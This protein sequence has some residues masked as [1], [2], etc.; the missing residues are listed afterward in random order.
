MKTHSRF[1]SFLARDIEQFLAHKRVLGRRYDV[2]EKTLVLL[3][4]Y[5]KLHRIGSLK[6][7]T[8]RLVDEF[9]LSRPRARPRSYN[10]L[11]CTLVRLFAYMV[12]RGRLALTPVQSPPR[13]SRYQRTPFIFDAANAERLLA[14][15]R[16]LP[17]R[18]GTIERGRVYYLV[19]AI[20]YGLGL[21]VGEVC[22]LRIRDFDSDRG[23]LVIRQSKFYK[24]AVQMT[25]SV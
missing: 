25:M 2:E 3:D 14:I 7:I 6:A 13:R 17:D 24:Y 4:R 21:R 10:H 22:R 16:S 15:A 19:F 23:V 18:S 20:L 1:T 8:P 5:L 12:N 11:R 9:L